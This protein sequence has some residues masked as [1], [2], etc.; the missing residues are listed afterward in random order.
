[1]RKKILILTIT[2]FFFT[3]LAFSFSFAENQP[4]SSPQVPNNLQE[5]TERAKTVAGKFPNVMTEVWQDAWVKIKNVWN[6]YIRSPLLN[7]WNK[8]KTFLNTE[9]EKR[10]PSVEEEFEKEKEEMKQEVKTEVPKIGKS[11]WE[12]LKDLFK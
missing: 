12:K 11:I 7:V 5:A 2:S 9:V 10:R 3:A 8:I 6:S 1:M 4:P